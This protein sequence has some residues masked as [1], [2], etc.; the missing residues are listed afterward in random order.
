MALP[1][2]LTFKSIPVF[3]EASGEKLTPTF[4]MV[5]YTGGKM[6]V[7]GF[8]HPVVV[9]FSGLE[10]PSQSIPI[11]LDHKPYQGVGHT[12]KISIDNNELTAE[13]LISRDTN[14]ARDV[15]NSGTKGFPWKA[16]IGGPILEAEF[17]PQGNTIEVNH[18]KF[19]GPVYVV[20][21]MTL[22]EISFVDNAADVN[23]NATVQAQSKTDVPPLAPS[24][25]PTPAILE[26]NV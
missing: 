8:P 23:T 16:S 18:Q 11:R 25:Q 2:F 6:N 9:E 1:N 24:A 17:V 21:K 10:I 12:T 19:E 5:A 22:K 13:G 20:R 3:L 4:N 14:W 15:A 7:D 26:G